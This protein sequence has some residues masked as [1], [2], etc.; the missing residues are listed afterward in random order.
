M[1][2]NEM[3]CIWLVISSNVYLE[4]IDTF[5]H[6]IYFS[7]LLVWC[8]VVAVNL[9]QLDILLFALSLDVS[10]FYLRPLCVTVDTGAMTVWR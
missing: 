3:C 4:R 6:L 1:S 9:F 7:Q 8:V 5:K 10:A 2:V